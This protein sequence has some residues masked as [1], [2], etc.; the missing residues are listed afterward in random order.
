MNDLT[1]TATDLPGRH[2]YPLTSHVLRLAIA[3]FLCRCAIGAF[4]IPPW[5]GPDEPPHYVVAEQVANGTLEDEAARA[6]LE[7]DVLQSM[8]LHEWWRGYRLPTPDPLPTRFTQEP[9][10]LGRGSMVQPLYYLAAGAVLRTA[11][12]TGLEPRYFVLRCFSALLGVATILMAWAGTRLLFDRVTANVVALI[13]ALHPQFLLSALSVTPESLA[14]ALGAFAW[15]QGARFVV[16]GGVA[17][18]MLTLMAVVA[19]ILTKR[20]AVPMFPGFLVV[21]A[22]GLY[23]YVRRSSLAAVV[24]MVAAP[25]MAAAALAVATNSA[26]P[27]RLLRAQWYSALFQVHATADFSPGHVI[28]FMAG[29]IDSSWLVAGWLRYP[30]PAWWLWCVRLLTVASVAG[31]I[32][33]LVRRTTLRVPLALTIV[34][35]ASM[36]FGTLVY[37]LMTGPAP[38]GRY[39]FV[40][41]APLAVLLWVGFVVWWPERLQWL[42]APALLALLLALDV[43][44]WIT[45]VLPAYV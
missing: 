19:A 11:H 45:T 25:L 31:V 20:N 26:E 28:A 1:T 21:I 5:Q 8:A 32:V 38:Q 4:L 29:L 18:P 6:R 9:E 44:G 27:V 43:T 42:A 41:A 13:G 15:W 35:A 7:R 12:V 22:A 2:R 14:N 30:A 37:G 40:V 33:T 17:A 10:H 24:A 34:L 3:L 36:V 23:P 39:L 16:A